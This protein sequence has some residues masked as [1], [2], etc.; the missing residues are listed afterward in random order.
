MGR[1]WTQQESGEQSSE[2][3]TLSWLPP[4]ITS[5]LTVSGSWALVSAHPAHQETEAAWFGR[6][7][8][9]SDR[10]CTCPRRE[11]LHLP[12]L[13][14]RLKPLE[15]SAPQRLMHCRRWKGGSAHEPHLPAAR[16]TSACAQP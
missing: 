16:T 8:L 11:C 13:N 12:G 14:F 1:P 4:S 5:M 6:F 3:S 7:M 2:K 10:A 15:S 9:S